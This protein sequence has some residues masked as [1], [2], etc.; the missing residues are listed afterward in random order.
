[1]FSFHLPKFAALKVELPTGGEAVMIHVGDGRFV[2]NLPPL[3][4]A[5]VDPNIEGVEVRDL[6]ITWDGE[7]LP[8]HKNVHPALFAFDARGAAE[9]VEKA[10]AGGDTFALQV[11]ERLNQA[12]KMLDAR[13]LLADPE[14]AADVQDAA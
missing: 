1:M 3:V 8:G 6:P 13:S 7:T 4:L 9:A 14:A 5:G 11:M 12:E 2:S 10:A